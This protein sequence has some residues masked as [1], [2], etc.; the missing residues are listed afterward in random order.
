MN[1]P[2]KRQENSIVSR[3]TGFK[4]LPIQLLLASLR[5]SAI[6]K[7]DNHSTARILS[8]AVVSTCDQG[9]R[10][11]EPINKS[12]KLTWFGRG[13]AVA[14]GPAAATAVTGALYGPGMPC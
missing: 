7:Y 8:S 4:Y 2:E 6:P 1:I 3:H 11:Q 14:G 12:R 5:P 9:D 13:P 10:L